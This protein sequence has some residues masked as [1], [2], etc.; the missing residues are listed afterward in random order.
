MPTLVLLSEAL[1]NFGLVFAALGGLVLAWRKLT[2]ERTQAG[3][4]AI[5]A[6]LARRAHVME[7]FN[8]AVGQLAD[9]RLE[10]RLCAI[11]VLREVS[12]NFPDLANPIFELL[13]VH[14]RERTSEYGD[15]APPIDVQAIIETLR[16]RIVSD[17]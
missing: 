1:R 8:R 12:F 11:Y 6:D 7:L 16:I 9:D 13:Q 2:P 10:V 3:S 14:L 17:E 4:S 5:Q 15:A